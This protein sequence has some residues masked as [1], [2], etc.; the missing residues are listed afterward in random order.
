VDQWCGSHANFVAIWGS[1]PTDIWIVAN[2]AGNIAGGKLPSS[3]DGGSALLH[4]DGLSWSAT[5]F[6]ASHALRAVWGSSKDDVW[7]V[8]Q[9]EMLLHFDGKSWT[10]IHLMIGAIE[11]TSVFGTSAR[12][13]WI[14]GASKFVMHFNGTSWTRMDATMTWD[15][16]RSG[17]SSADEVWVLGDTTLNHFDGKS[18]SSVTR[19]ANSVQSSV[20]GRA[21]HEAWIAGQAGTIEHW[22]SSGEQRGTDVPGSSGTANFRALW[23]RTD[24]DGWA[25]GEKG[26]LAHWSDA[27]WSDG[28]HL[29]DSNLN[30]AWSYGDST[31]FV[32]D[33]GTFLEF[34]G[35]SWSANPL[36]ARGAKRLWGTS[37]RDVWAVGRE[38]LHWDGNFWQVV[39]RPGSDEALALWGSGSADT[40]ATGTNGLLLHWDGAAWQ[41]SQSPSSADITGIWGS[42]S[43]DIWAVDTYGHFLHY[44]GIYW[45]ISSAQNFGPLTSVWG[46]T[47]SDIIAISGS[48]RIQYNGTTWSLLPRHPKEAPTYKTAFGNGSLVWIGGN[49]PWSAYKAGG[50]RAELGRWDGNAMADDLEPTTP[51]EP[52]ILNYTSVEAGWADSADDMW[53][54]LSGVV[55]WDGAK[56]S[57][58]ATGGSSS[59]TALWGTP[60]DLWALTRAGQIINKA[61]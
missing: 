48:T 59:V 49:V 20:W 1:S 18:W 42:S 43:R 15:V 6:D 29:T 54:A 32:G 41:L 52:I 4:W 14:V 11:L 7:V 23:G 61:R 53:L 40:W 35:Q 27:G 21:G 33:G 39:A 13:V 8:G 30:A 34:D 56:W 12:D 10:P 24:S 31:W 44:D 50:A 60:S 37:A 58:S 28:P 46:R 19:P 38:F 47:A 17:W 45:R 55:H 5:Q 57:Y 2:E 16:F 36:A 3:I 9:N 22:N 51:P 25:V 26:R